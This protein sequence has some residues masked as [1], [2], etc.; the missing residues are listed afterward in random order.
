MLI[1]VF[2]C[3][4]LLLFNVFVGF[5]RDLLC[6]A[7]WFVFLCVLSMFAL[8]CEIVFVRVACDV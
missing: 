4:C 3:E 6:G 2:V 5:V 8:F 1:C 7:V